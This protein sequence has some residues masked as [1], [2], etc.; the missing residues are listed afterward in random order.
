MN[1]TPYR[2]I[3]AH[4]ALSLSPFDLKKFIVTIISLRSYPGRTAQVLTLLMSQNRTPPQLEVDS[5]MTLA[6][7][8]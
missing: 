7:G 5:Y 2:S 3:N 8:V 4:S 1:L 6:G